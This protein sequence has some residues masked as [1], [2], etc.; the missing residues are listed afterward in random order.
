MAVLKDKKTGKFYFRFRLNRKEYEKWFGKGPQGKA[1]AEMAFAEI[2]QDLRLNRGAETWDCFAK[3]KKAKKPKTFGEAAADF[4]ELRAKRKASTLAAYNSIL[5]KDLLP[6][7]GNVPLNEMNDSDLSKFQDT[8]SD[9]VSASRTNTVMQLLRSILLKEYKRGTINRNPCDD[10]ERLDEPKTKIDPLSEQDLE[11][12][13]AHIEPHYR[14]L[15]T[16]LAFTGARPN[17]IIALRWNDI[18]WKL[19]QIDI[20]KGRV[21]G[22]EGT[23]KTPSSERVIPMMDRVAQCLDDHRKKHHAVIVLEYKDYVFTTKKGEPI[24]KHLDR[25]WHRALRKAGLKHRPSY[26]LR[27]TFA[28]QCIIKGFPLP[29][30]AKVLGH[31]TIDTLIRHYL[32]WI[33]SATKDQDAKLKHAFREAFVPANPK[34][35]N[36]RGNGL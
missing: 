24:N 4:M 1:D 10:V 21:R 9:R 6:K 19:G 5:K 25:I 17:E 18:D 26:Q 32:G 34:E 16:T 27:H 14:A 30:I 29:Y 31:S 3:L 22:A 35:G 20:S 15:F 7:F 12:A 8:L 33:D 36:E 28:T 2:Q 23:P 13:L 11:I